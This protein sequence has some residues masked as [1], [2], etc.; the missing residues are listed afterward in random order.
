MSSVNLVILVGHLTREPELRYAASGTAVCN[1]G[2]ATNERVKL[3]NGDWGDKTEF[4][5][6]VLFG[7][8]AETLQKYCKKGKQIYIEGR[9]QTQKWEDKE[10]GNPRNKTE[11]VVNKMQMLGKKDEAVGEVDSLQDL[12][13]DNDKQAESKA[14]PIEEDEDLP[15]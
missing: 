8:T 13:H 4:H 11:V 12:V 15:F 14:P 2:L 5:N 1:V 10:T 9:L 6:L 3:P 7:K